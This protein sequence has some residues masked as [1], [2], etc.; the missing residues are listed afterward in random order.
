MNGFLWSSG[1]IGW[2]VFASVVF[3]GL[4]WLFADLVWR[5]TSTRIAR[6][7]AAMVAGWVVGVCL[8]LLGFWLGSR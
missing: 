2:G 6:L 5:L 8:I 3:S 7:A 1:H 4:W